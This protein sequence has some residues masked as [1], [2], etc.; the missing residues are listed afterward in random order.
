MKFSIKGFEG[1]YELDDCGS[2]YNA[3]TGFRLKASPDHKGYPRVTLYPANGPRWSNAYV[4]QLV[5]EVF[6]G[7]CPKGKEVNHIDGDKQNSRPSNLEY[8]TASENILHLCRV[9]GK[10]AGTSSY[11]ATVDADKLAEIRRRLALHETGVSI[12]RDLRL[13]ASCVSAIKTGRT[14]LVNA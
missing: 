12:A 13:K 2:V 1:R 6:L 9:L 7:P 5:A 8:V 11:Q 4:H 10:R 14:Y 3:R